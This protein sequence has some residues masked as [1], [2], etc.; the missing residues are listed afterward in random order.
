MPHV[1][2]SLLTIFCW[3]GKYTFALS[4]LS[5]W[6]LGRYRLAIM[7]DGNTLADPLQPTSTWTPSTSLSVLLVNLSTWSTSPCG[8]P[9]RACPSTC[10]RTMASTI[11]WLAGLR[12]WDADWLDC[13]GGSDAGYRAHGPHQWKMMKTAI[14]FIAMAM[15][16]KTDVR[17]YQHTPKVAVILA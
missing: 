17:E 13:C 7:A 5:L 12:C 1:C 16:C 8:P 4:P 14:W 11:L 10:P 2:Q 6:L 15:S 3:H 9:G